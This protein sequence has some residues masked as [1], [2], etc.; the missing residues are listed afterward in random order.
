MPL[1]LLLAARPNVDE[2]CGSPAWGWSRTGRT[3]RSKVKSLRTRSASRDLPRRLGYHRRV[4][5]SNRL[6]AFCDR[7]EPPLPVDDELGEVLDATIAAGQEEEPDLNFDEVEFSRFLAGYCSRDDPKGDLGEL[8]PGDL[9]LVFGCTRGE[10][11][12]LRR[13]DT[14]FGRDI[15][16]AL[17]RSRE[18]ELDTDDFRQSLY[19]K[20]FAPGPSGRSRMAD[21]QGRADLR[22]WLRVVTVRMVIDLVRR[23]KRRDLGHKADEAAVLELPA[24]EADPELAY[25]R[26]RYQ[27]EL[28]DA[29]REAFDSLSPRERNLLRHFLVQGSSLDYVGQIYD[30]HR[31]TVFRWRQKAQR[32]LIDATRDALRERLGQSREFDS[33]VR[34]LDSQFH[35]TLRDLGPDGLRKGASGG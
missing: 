7:F 25:V 32:A 14:R 2:A 6:R 29:L 11:K 10:T 5:V 19:S 15:D 33:L 18:L 17:A 1:G 21:Y 22:S 23:H 28:R 24:M 35:L 20:L 16:V 9:L 13:F 3:W 8:R 12:A 27:Q 34:M 26:K 4:A 31:T 30:V